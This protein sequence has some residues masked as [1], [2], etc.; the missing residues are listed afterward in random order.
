MHC[1]SECVLCM[2]SGVILLS[3]ATPTRL[4]TFPDLLFSSQ[5]CACAEVRGNI[6][7]HI[8]PIPS[9]VIA[10][11]AGGADVDYRACGTGV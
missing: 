9:L 6:T 4:R 10:S 5:L 11:D 8:L 2:R 3:T 7:V 1:S